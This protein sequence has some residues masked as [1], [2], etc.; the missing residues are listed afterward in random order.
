MSKPIRFNAFE[1]NCVGHQS[2]GLWAHPRDRSWQYKDLE[3]WTDLARTLE[4]GI[5][6]GIFIADVIGYYDVYQ[7]SNH[8]A[9]HQGVQIPVNDPIQLAA[10]IAL[11]TEHLGI[12]ITAS[13]SFEHPYTFANT[14]SYSFASADALF[15]NTLKGDGKTTIKSAVDAANVLYNLL[16]VAPAMKT[17]TGGV[18]ME[19]YIAAPQA[20]Y[21]AYLQD[22]ADFYQKGPG[23]QEANPVTYRMATI[24]RDDFFA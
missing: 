19:K 8:H 17:E 15:S 16:Q 3:Y 11:A 22:A 1:M 4:K 7:G 24:L 20:R 5:F 21:L 9:L 12:G 2:P 14:G 18:S 13:T 6:D 10:P 23:V